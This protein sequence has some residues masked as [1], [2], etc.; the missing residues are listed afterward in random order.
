MGRLGPLCARCHNMLTSTQCDQSNRSLVIIFS[1]HPCLDLALIIDTQ[2]SMVVHIPALTI[3]QIQIFSPSTNQPVKNL[4]RFKDVA[5]CGTF[6][7][8]GQ[9]LIAGG[10]EGQVRLFDVHTKSMLRVFKDHKRCAKSVL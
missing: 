8:D 9:L 1:F 2:N 4:T 5:Y 10:E 7:D 6:R 3:L